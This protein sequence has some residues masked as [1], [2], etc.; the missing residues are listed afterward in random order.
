MRKTLSKMKVCAKTSRRGERARAEAPEAEA[1][2]GCGWS[3][4]PRASGLRD[5][6]GQWWRLRRGSGARG[7]RGGG[8][9]G[10]ARARVRRG[11]H[12]VQGAEGTGPQTCWQ[13]LPPAPPGRGQGQGGK[14]SVGGGRRS[15]ARAQP[16]SESQKPLR[17][18]RCREP[19]NC[20][21]THVTPSRGPGRGGTMQG[22]ATKAPA[23]QKPTHHSSNSV[24]GWGGVRA[25]VTPTAG[26]SGLGAGHPQR[27]AACVVSGS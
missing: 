12:G 19:K 23:P 5:G 15:E 6:Q 10:G 4:A 9:G 27:E 22:E 8:L 20:S 3:S 17:D 2:A 14:S 25:L 7:H 24:L 26:G 18:W 16:P 1:L 13:G 21:G 11:G